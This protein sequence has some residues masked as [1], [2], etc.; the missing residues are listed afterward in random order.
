MVTPLL[1][2]DT[3]HRI[4]AYFNAHWLHQQLALYNAEYVMRFADRLYKRFFNDGVLT[5]GG[6][7]AGTTSAA[8][9]DPAIIAESA[10]WGDSVATPRPRRM[11]HRC[12]RDST[13][14]HKPRQHGA[15]PGK[16]HRLRQ[17]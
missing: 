5:P 14:H 3:N 7:R 17:Q 9:L 8:Q 4:E 10:R 6:V 15:H 12:R 2:L 11:A 1:S 13:F 16:G